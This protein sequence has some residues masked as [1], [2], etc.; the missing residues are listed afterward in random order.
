MDVL[1]PDLTDSV[2][3][4]TKRTLLPAR[5]IEDDK[6]WGWGTTPSGLGPSWTGNQF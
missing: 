6:V 5:T 1:S 4:L 2:R 3:S